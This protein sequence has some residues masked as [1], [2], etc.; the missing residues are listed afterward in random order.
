MTISR[1]SPSTPKSEQ[2]VVLLCSDISAGGPEAISA[3][4]IALALR[5]HVPQSQVFI[6]DDLCS[7]STRVSAVL[8]SLRAHRVAVGCRKAA[9]RRGEFLAQLRRAHIHPSGVQ[10]VDLMPAEGS[11]PVAVGEQSVARLRAAL[12]RLSRADLGAPVHDRLAPSTTG[13]S[14]RSLFGLGAIPRRPVAFFVEGR[15]ERVSCCHA[16]V[17]ACPRGAIHLRDG[18]LVIDGATCTGCGACLSVCPSGAMSL[19]GLSIGELEAAASALVAAAT[20]PRTGKPLGVAIVCAKAL[21]DVPLGGSWLPLEVPSLEMV[22][23]GWP[24]Q[25]LSAGAGVSLVGCHEAA[26]H[27]RAGELTRFCGDVLDRFAPAR[28]Q[29]LGSPG[30]PQ[31]VVLNGSEQ[32]LPEPPASVKLREPEASAGAL[33]TLFARSPGSVSA[34]PDEG[35]TT[36]SLKPRTEREARWR[37]ESPMAPLGEITIDNA[38]CSACGCCVLACPTGTLQASQKGGTIAFSFESSACSAC[39][40]CVSS[41]PEGAVSLLRVLD[42]MSPD[43]GRQTIAE[44]SVG[45]RCGACGQPLADGLVRSVLAPRLAGSHPGIAAWLR[46]GDRCGDCVLMGRLPAHLQGGL[47]AQGSRTGGSLD[48]GG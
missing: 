27:A 11:D 17:E 33:A 3:G 26:C 41:C 38:R 30:R 36:I 43:A 22:S 19:N 2:T 25:I 42:S 16:C 14:R 24:L 1:V 34:L 9:E 47:P 21:A 15:C 35:P 45:A 8:Q 4:D 20:R 7:E 5:R 37:I 23:A 13:V 28:R 18:R 48:P 6:V 46:D 32:R 39:G 10:I 29:L 31:S 44:V 40:G 12:A